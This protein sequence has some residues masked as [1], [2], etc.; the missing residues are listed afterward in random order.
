V[1]GPLLALGTFAAFC[2]TISWVPQLVRILHRR[3]ADDV[4]WAYLALF[5]IGVSSWLLYG[6]GR[7]DPALI[8]ANAVTLA[9]LACVSVA[10]L[11]LERDT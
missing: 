11:T 2:T 8:A 6:V 7:R 4:S 1:S 9:L 3:A 5:T 10:K